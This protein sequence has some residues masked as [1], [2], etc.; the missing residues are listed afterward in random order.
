M[1]VVVVAASG[2]VRVVPEVWQ[3]CCRRGGAV[4]KGRGAGRARPRG[5]AGAGSVDDAAASAAPGAHSGRERSAASTRCATLQLRTH[6]RA[7]TPARLPDTVM[8][9]DSAVMCHRFGR[10]RVPLHLFPKR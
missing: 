7:T 10:E 3:A 2:M 8:L 6:E 5:G 1:V 9:P 4:C